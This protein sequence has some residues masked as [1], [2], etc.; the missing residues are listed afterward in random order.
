[1]VLILPSVQLTLTARFKLP[2]V[3]PGCSLGNTARVAR[4]S[5]V[6]RPNRLWIIK[7]A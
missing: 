6:E 2:P 7:F 3:R 1:M 5:D 4:G